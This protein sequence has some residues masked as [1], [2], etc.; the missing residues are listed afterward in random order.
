MVNNDSNFKSIELL[1]CWC[2]KSLPTVFSDALSYNQQV[3]L[4]TKAINDMTNTINGLP[5]YIIELVKELLNQLNLEEIV[6]EVLADLYFLN[7]K[8][9]PNNMTAAVGDGV[10]DDTAAIQAMINYTGVQRKYLFFPA[11]NY[12]VTGLTAVEN[13]SLIGLDRYLSIIT[14][15]PDSNRDL[16]TGFVKNISISNLTLNANMNGQT[17]NCSCLNATV[18]NALIDFVIFRNGYDSVVIENTNEFEGAY[19][20]F[21]GIQHNALTLNGDG[22]VIYNVIFKNASQLSANALAV[23]NGN[24][25]ISGIYSNATIPNGVVITA[26]GASVEGT[27]LN[28]KNTITGGTGN[29]INIVDEK[30]TEIFSS[31][32]IENIAAIKETNATDI[33][34]NPTN[35]LKYGTVERLSDY[36]DSVKMQDKNGNPYNVLVS[37][38]NTDIVAVGTPVNCFIVSNENAPQNNLILYKDKVV[39]CDFGQRSNAPV[40]KQKLINNNISKIDTLIL[41]HYDNDHAEGLPALYEL[42]G[43]DLNNA[44]IYLPQTPDF[45]KI[46]NPNIKTYYDN[47]Q[48]VIRECN[49]TAVIPTEHQT[50]QLLDEVTCTFFNVNHTK[51]YN[52]QNF[53]YNDC[54]L[55]SYIQYDNISLFLSADIQLEAQQALVDDNKLH[56]CNILSVPHHGFNRWVNGGILY[57]KLTP[58]WCFTQSSTDLSLNNTYYLEEKSQ[59]IYQIQLRNIPNYLNMYSP[60]FSFQIYKNTWKFTSTAYSPYYN[61]F[62]RQYNS[63]DECYG[64]Y[65]E[66]GKKSTPTDINI[67]DLL[68]NMEYNSHAFFSAGSTYTNLCPAQMQSY[69]CFVDISLSDSGLFTHSSNHTT[70]TPGIRGYRAAVV[71]YIPRNFSNAG[72]KFLI[73]QYFRKSSSS[74]E[75]EVTNGLFTDVLLGKYRAN[76]VNVTTTETILNITPVMSV[77]NYFTLSNNQ[78]DINSG[79]PCNIMISGNVT[80]AGADTQWIKI[81]LKSGTTKVVTCVLPLVPLNNNNTYFS[82]ITT[83]SL[84][85][86][87]VYTINVSASTALS[88]CNIEV[89]FHRASPLSNYT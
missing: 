55:C 31:N 2:M 23:I 5:D 75:W 89:A 49:M 81:Q 6:K 4:L 10:T 48:N 76:N 30:G 50:V 44:T 39:M 40:L 56:P 59:E 42:G 12:L 58:D 86:P 34:L 28:A 35:P 62:I 51:Y 38:E 63:I 20:L 68:N 1:R 16:I 70:T 65:D 18:E 88:N 82:Y 24:N 53:V 41:S 80:V 25:K 29:Y 19:W 37:N 36:Y 13:V 71:T 57:D 45:S 9:P 46:T 87:N 3:C 73:R 43:I 33:F 15:A 66:Y 22:A 47:I 27:I 32:V 64:G 60:D 74:A 61:K 21:D 72:S 7:V 85:P 14:L 17:S 84:N 67:F 11:G 83:V 69:G 78:L 79:G 26:S 77:G 52:S 8:N 54:C